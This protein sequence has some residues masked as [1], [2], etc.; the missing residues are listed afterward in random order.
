MKNTKIVIYEFINPFKYSL[1]I[2]WMFQ[3]SLEST[4]LSTLLLIWAICGHTMT[5]PTLCPII[6]WATIWR[7]ES[8]SGILALMQSVKTSIPWW[9]L[10]GKLKWQ[11]KVDLSMF[12]SIRSIL[13]LGMATARML[14][15]VFGKRRDMLKESQM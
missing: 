8:V 7:K 10:F 14:R 4:I 5:W 2:I 13:V 15:L 9:R 11:L 12:L 3:L 1:E 6:L